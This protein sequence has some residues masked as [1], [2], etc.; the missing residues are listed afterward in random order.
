MDERAVRLLVVEDDEITLG[1]LREFLRGRGYEVR[2]AVSGEECMQSLEREIPDLVLMDM[3]LPDLNGLQVLNQIRSNP[4]Y[5]RLPVV[6]MSTDH[7]DDL[8]VEA[9]NRGANEFVNKPV[10]HDELEIR[11][12]HIL[13]QK[14]RISESNNLRMYRVTLSQSFS[15][16][17]LARIKDESAASHLNGEKLR[18]TVLL[19]NL[20]GLTRRM[21]SLAP[22]PIVDVLNSISS[23]VME[24]IFRNQ[25][26]VNK[27]AGDSFL[28]AFGYPFSTGAEP[29]NAVTCALEIAERMRV[30][31]AQYSKDFGDDLRACI[32]VATGDLFA[33]FVGGFRRKEYVIIGPAIRTAHTLE[34]VSLK[35]R[36]SVIVDE[37]TAQE[38]GSDFEKVQLRVRR[39][40]GNSWTAFGLPGKMNLPSEVC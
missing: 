29:R 36:F 7:S 18:A 4:R 32:G 14:N 38:A 33:G 16:D 9:L 17:V 25:G 21:M 20:H 27:F 26:S 11:L 8:T 39:R 24:I 19:M 1:I 37:A 28:V 10:R 6:L 5:L 12:R 40:T 30:L 13:D 3:H 34:R 31:H 2:L 22:G 23:D 35:T 15:D